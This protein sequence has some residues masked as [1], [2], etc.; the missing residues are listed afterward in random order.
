MPIIK[1]GPAITLAQDGM[2]PSRLVPACCHSL[3]RVPGRHTRGRRSI[4]VAA[5]A[6]FIVS[7]QYIPARQAQAWQHY[8]F[9]LTTYAIRDIESN[10][11]ALGYG[12]NTEPEYNAN[13]GLKY[14]DRMS[15]LAS[16]LDELLP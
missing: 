14:L 4:V 10:G 13:N 6:S 16:R 15:S 1:F 11:A 12:G 8:R 5:E 3:A 7:N 2:L 9:Y